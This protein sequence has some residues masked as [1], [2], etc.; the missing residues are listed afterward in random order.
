MVL[1]KESM[2]PRICQSAATPNPA[3]RPAIAAEARNPNIKR[4]RIVVFRDMFFNSPYSWGKTH[5]GSAGS[6]AEPGS[7]ESIFSNI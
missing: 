1:V 7:D 4:I 6:P 5:P 2:V 3:Q